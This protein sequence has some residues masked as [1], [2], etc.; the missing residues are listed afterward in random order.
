MNKI[1][2]HIELSPGHVTTATEDEGVGQDVQDDH[3]LSID[4]NEQLDV[5]EAQSEVDE[6]EEP[7]KNAK[8]VRS[9]N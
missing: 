4:D 3:M 5:G 6:N 1:E 8:A 7:P 2:G 9:K